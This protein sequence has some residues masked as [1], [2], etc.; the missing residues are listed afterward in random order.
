MNEKFKKINEFLFRY[1]QNHLLN[2]YDELSPVNQEKL[3]KQI[4]NIDFENI[5]HLYDNSMKDEEISLDDISPLIHYEKN[6]FSTED[7][8]Y[9]TEIGNKV[10]S[11]GSFAVVT[12]AGG[13]GTRLGYKGPKGTYMLDL[14]PNK[15]SLFEIMCDD[16]KD[17][18]KQFNTTLPWYIMTSTTNDFETKKFFEMN[19]YFD[20]PKDKITFFKQE[21]LPLISINKDLILDELHIV[22]E[23]SNGNGNVFKSLKNNNILKEM[24]SNNIKW[25]SFGG[26]DNVLLKNI[27]PLFLGLTIDKNLQ[28]A[29]KSIFKK[30]PLEKTAVYCKKCGKPSI[31][32]YDMI[33]LEISESKDSDG[34]Y[35]YREANILSH[36]MSLNAVKKISEIDL[37]YHRAFKKNTFINDEGMKQIPDKPNTFKFENFIFDA[38]EYFDDMLLLRVNEEEE[39]APIKDFTSKYN[40]DTALKKY[41]VFF[42]II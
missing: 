28:I 34:L 2:F 4:E 42:N 31:L 35:L 20:Y 18:N 41:N 38:F 32:Y 9:Y 27:D 30:E 40:P 13:Q 23:A 6:R 5:F 21:Q 24:E 29:S 39:F 10:V 15:K 11:S 8:K 33:D 1:N 22:K 16:L 19:N 37:K 12:L 26:I 14:K 36:L 25:I 7:I 17:F 3:L